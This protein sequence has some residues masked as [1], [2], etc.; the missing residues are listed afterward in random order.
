MAPAPACILPPDVHSLD[1]LEI[2]LDDAPQIDARVH[3]TEQRHN[4]LPGRR[5]HV[6]PCR[7]RLALL[8]QPRVLLQQVWCGCTQDQLST[9]CFVR[10]ADWQ[11]NSRSR[12]CKP[13][14]QLV[15]VREL[16]NVD[17]RHRAVEQQYPQAPLQARNVHLE[18]G[19]GR[20]LS[21]IDRASEASEEF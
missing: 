8:E 16:E 21:A 2:L 15:D 13:V 1:R 18:K 6:R 4:L 20:S 19:K 10:A 17:H 11:A 3:R 9:G 14:S 12:T 5:L 7:E